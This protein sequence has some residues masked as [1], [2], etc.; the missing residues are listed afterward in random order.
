MVNIY[1]LSLMQV[2]PPFLGHLKLYFSGIS[3]PFLEVILTACRSQ[4]VRTSPP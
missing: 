3:F 4:G 2:G 1:Y